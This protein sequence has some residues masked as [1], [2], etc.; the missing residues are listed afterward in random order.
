MRRILVRYGL[1]MTSVV[2]VAFLVP[3]GLLAR[4]LAHDRA[5]DGARADAQRVAVF[6]SGAPEDRVRLEAELL[7]V[8]D[9]PRR[10]TVFASDGS[11]IGPD[12]PRS[13]AVQLGGLG[14]AAAAR[15]DG[16]TEVVLPVA[17]S[18]GVAVVRTLV[19]DAE[20]DRGVARAWLVLAAV[21]AVLLGGTA[22]AG[23][24]LA[25][26][27]SRSVLELSEVA[28]RLGAGDLDARVQPSG[29]PEVAT[30]GRVLN[31][32]GARVA[33]L[34]AAERELVA[35]LSHRL[36]TPI[37][38]LRLDVDLVEDPGTRAR[39]GDHVDEL[40]RA[41]D[42]IVRTARHP[43]GAGPATSDVAGVVRDRARFWSVLAAAQE[44]PLR[45]RVPEVPVHVPLA[46]AVVGAALDVL[47]D[48]VFSHTPS[49]T[50]FAITVHVGARA[51]GPAG[52]PVVEV[53]VEDDGVGF[54]EELAERGRSGGGSTGLGL[55]VARRA[56]EDAGG[57]LTVGRSAT[58]GARVT[59]MLP[60][61]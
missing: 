53:V 5:L 12:A 15:T 19:P 61:A 41:V 22:L 47:V 35:D 18:S 25:T 51:G 32:L 1:A 17:G 43:E 46:D 2:L 26:R 44:R 34:L 59:L 23:R 13:P 7:A 9:S 40:V 30:V 16:G 56:A 55:D 6:A 52:P 50:G 58:G 11:V 21:G 29:P 48:N 4:T 39:L 49:G 37:T 27:L 3:L 36:R 31:G 33:G 54:A 57:R 10:T 38:A 28:G 14:T 42:D 20:L 60:T 8:N 24:R 45:T